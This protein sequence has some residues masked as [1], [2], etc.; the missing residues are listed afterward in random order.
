MPD[1]RVN[2]SSNP[3]LTSELV[4]E[5]SVIDIV[6]RVTDNNGLSSIAFSV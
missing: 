2:I 1:S 4:A 5:G 3:P 6:A